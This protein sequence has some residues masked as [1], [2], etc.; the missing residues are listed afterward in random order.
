MNCEEFS[1]LDSNGIYHL[2]WPAGY[3]MTSRMYVLI[4]QILFLMLK[5][6]HQLA[7]LL[8]VF[9]LAVQ[10]P[11]IIIMVFI[12]LLESQILGHQTL[13]AIL[14]ASYLAS[15]LPSFVT[16]CLHLFVYITNSVDVDQ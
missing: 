7:Y 9:S 3:L 16:I 1:C 2:L 11:S 14:Y 8:E 5:S 12:F 15:D 10:G 4:A 13:L 6:S